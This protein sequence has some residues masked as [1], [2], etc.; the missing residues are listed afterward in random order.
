MPATGNNSCFS[1]ADRWRRRRRRRLAQSAGLVLSPRAREE[2]RRVSLRQTA[3][4]RCDG[5]FCGQLLLPLQLLQAT[6]CETAADRDYSTVV[7]C[8]SSHDE[9]TST[10]DITDHS[11]YSI[12]Y[13][14][15]TV[16]TSTTIQYE[17]M[18]VDCGPFRGRRHCGGNRKPGALST[19]AIAAG[20]EDRYKGPQRFRQQW[21]HE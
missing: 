10:Q 2:S 18:N 7:L 9:A 11:Q 3:F 1:R 20:D 21:R 15:I 19:V 6:A 5:R 8:V 17:H 14:S 4:L 12:Q 13:T 16:I